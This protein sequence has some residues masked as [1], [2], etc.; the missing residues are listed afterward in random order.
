MP[1]TTRRTKYFENTGKSMSFV[2]K[3]CDALDEYNE[4]WDFIKE[5]LSI[6][7]HSMTVHDEKFIK[8]EVRENNSSSSIQLLLSLAV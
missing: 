5:I 2:I 4:I 6:K 1:Q 7:F 3:H 8:A